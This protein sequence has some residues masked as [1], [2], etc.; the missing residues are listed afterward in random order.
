MQSLPIKIQCEDALYPILKD[1]F[2]SLCK[3]NAE[4]TLEPLNMV[5]RVISSPPRLP[6]GVSSVVEMPTAKCYQQ[7]HRYFY[8][9]N[10]G[11][12]IQF[13]SVARNVQGFIRPGIQNDMSTICSLVSC[14][15]IETLKLAGRFYL[16]AAALSHNGIGYL[17]TG[18]GG[19]GKTTSALNLVRNGFDYVSDDS[20]IFEK[21]DGVIQV[22]PWYYEFHISPDICRCYDELQ[23]LFAED[24]AEGEKFSVD[25][26]R[27]F[28]GAP[29]N[30]IAPDVILFPRICSRKTSMLSPLGH[31]EMFTR[32]I[33][34]IPLGLDPVLTERQ[35]E[36]IKT[37][38]HQT[39]GY[40]L[41]AGRDLLEDPDKLSLLITNLPIRQ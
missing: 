14:P 40:A 25:V 1:F 37:L 30:W 18:D 34:Q 26:S 27:Y 31:M 35:L 10:D 4:S 32:L 41:L 8:T 11:S 22:C 2:D 21:R 13:D 33:K 38:V 17:I 7:G 28:K 19:S 23:H 12:M 9:A 39:R 6:A 24:L 5:V 29:K 20:L 3:G 16:H 36:M 15:L